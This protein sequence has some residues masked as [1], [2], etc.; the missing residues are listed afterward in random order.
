MLISDRFF[1]YCISNRFAESRSHMFTDRKNLQLSNQIVCAAPLDESSEVFLP[2]T[3]M[4]IVYTDV[5]ML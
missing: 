1:V 2:G 3:F 4:M 5:V